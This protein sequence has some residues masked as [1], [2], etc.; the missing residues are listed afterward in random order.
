MFGNKISKSFAL[1]F[2]IYIHLLKEDMSEAHPN[3]QI[4]Q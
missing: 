4:N 1:A 3:P 2:I